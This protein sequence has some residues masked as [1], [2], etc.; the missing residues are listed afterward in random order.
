MAT[1]DASEHTALHCAG[2]SFREP[3]IEESFGGAAAVM[4]VAENTTSRA[5]DS[6][7]RGGQ[8]WLMIMDN[9]N[10]N[11]S[12]SMTRAGPQ[13]VKFGVASSRMSLSVYYSYETRLGKRPE[14]GEGPSAARRLRAITCLL[15]MQLT[16]S[17]RASR[18][19]SARTM[20]LDQIHDVSAKQA[21]SH[22]IRPTH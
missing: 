8:I 3:R 5:P 17:R 6:S 7:E 1:V 2:F 22:H 13:C 12:P 10:E 11:E 19:H 21:R 16:N 9:E 20:T 18:K 14:M 15:R 4:A